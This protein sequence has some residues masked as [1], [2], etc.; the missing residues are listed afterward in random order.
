MGMIRRSQT[1]LISGTSG[2][3]LAAALAE[4][5]VSP[6]LL[7]A[8]RKIISAGPLVKT[9]GAKASDPGFGTKVLERLA[10]C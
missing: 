4:E 7:N 6:R 1:A 2:C 3:D 9:I 5:S 8:V 10:W